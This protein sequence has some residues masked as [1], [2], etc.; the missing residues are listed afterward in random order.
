M[1]GQTWAGGV[2]LILLGVAIVARTA[3][4]TLIPHLRKA[5]GP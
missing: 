5:V 4:G 1:T 3:K 2:V